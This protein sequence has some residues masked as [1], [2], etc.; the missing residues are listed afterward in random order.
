M[1]EF[2]Q[3]LLHSSSQCAPEISILPSKGLYSDF[4]LFT[5]QWGTT[6]MCLIQKTNIFFFFFQYKFKLYNATTKMCRKTLLGPT[7]GTPIKK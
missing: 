1:M 7:Y 4:Y 3:T 2:N 5:S 6:D